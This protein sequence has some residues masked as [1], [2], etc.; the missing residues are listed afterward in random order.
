MEKKNRQKR[1]DTAAIVAEIQ[2]V[3]AAYV[4]MIING[5]R[6]NKTIL[7]TY[8]QLQEGKRRLIETVKDQLLRQNR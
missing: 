1:D 3:S 7:K 6:K 4:R 8:L 2:G 5:K